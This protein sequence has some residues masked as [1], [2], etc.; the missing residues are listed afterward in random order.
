MHRGIGCCPLVQSG[1][2]E[3][4]VVEFSQQWEVRFGQAQLWQQPGSIGR[5][6]IETL[7][8][9]WGARHNHTV[10]GK[11]GMFGQCTSAS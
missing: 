5:L 1:V 4:R 9:V 10:N 6:G 3:F 8:L 11:Q 2:L 7:V